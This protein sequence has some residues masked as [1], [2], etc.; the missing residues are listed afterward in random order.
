MNCGAPTA[1]NQI[2]ASLWEPA[3]QLRAKGWSFPRR[4]LG[5]THDR[6]H[7]NGA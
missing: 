3:K 4:A 5:T 7:A 6:I 1:L 2:E